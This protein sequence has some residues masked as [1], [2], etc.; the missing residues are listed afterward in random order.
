MD[1]I[2]VLNGP[3]MNL[4]GQREPDKYGT[5]TL[6][7]INHDLRQMA[8]DAG[9]PIQIEQSN[10]EGEL[11]QW[12]HQ[13][14]SQDVLIINPAAWTHYSYAIRDAI[15]GVQVPTIEVHLSNI[16]ARDE[17]RK[18]SVIAPVCIGQISGLGRHSYS[19]AMHYAINH[20]RK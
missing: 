15:A 13:M 4:L 17:F 19:L 8:D 16:H 7:Q 10:F 5:Q 9:I 20:L 11:I 3:N 1:K 2:W 12:I 14:D 18:I 6:D